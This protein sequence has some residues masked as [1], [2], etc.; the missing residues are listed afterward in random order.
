MF[1]ASGF[2]YAKELETTKQ[3]GPFAV[4][5]KL[6]KNP[7]VVGDNNL[8]LIIKDVSGKPVKDAK[9]IVNYEM[10]AMPG[11]PAMRYKVQPVLQGEA[12]VGKVNFSM[13]GAWGLNI[14]ISQGAKN[15]SAKMN[16]DVQ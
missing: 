11:M 3:A 8:S 9:V 16:V 2:A 15:A 7:P 1:I 5:I 14:K 12:Y 6:D 4:T 10:P 13:G